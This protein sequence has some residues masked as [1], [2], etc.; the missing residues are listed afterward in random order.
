MLENKNKEG[1]E[2]YVA[3]GGRCCNVYKVLTSKV[4]LL[5]RKNAKAE[6]KKEITRAA[7]E[8]TRRK[9]EPQKKKKQRDEVELDLKIYENKI[10]KFKNQRLP[11]QKKVCNGY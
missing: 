8:V 1:D 6:N 3:G 4:E 5:C 2:L 11:R 9:E 10:E 7:M